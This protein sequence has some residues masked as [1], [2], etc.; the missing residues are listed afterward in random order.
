MNPRPARPYEML[1][2]HCLTR[3]LPFRLAEFGAGTLQVG[4]RLPSDRETWA[5]DENSPAL[6]LLSPFYTGSLALR[7]PRAPLAP[8][9]CHLVVF[10]A[11]VFS[12]FPLAAL[13]QEGFRLLLPGG[14]L[15]LEASAPAPWTRWAGPGRRWP[16]PRRFR[17][18]REA[19]AA[20]GALPASLRCLP[21]TLS[22]SPLLSALIPYYPWLAERRWVVGLQGKDS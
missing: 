11:C 17:E 6:R 12:S 18:T 13:V 5:L 3:P 22:P 10:S 4:A 14:E 8:A 2:R 19:L 15:W 7:E 21:F 1:V 20:H 16:A 9:S